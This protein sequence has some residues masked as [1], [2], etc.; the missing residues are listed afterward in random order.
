MYMLR[1][2]AELSVGW[3]RGIEMAWYMGGRCGTA[4]YIQP[5]HICRNF[6]LRGLSGRGVGVGEPCK[7]ERKKEK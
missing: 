6:A 5:R 3:E 2:R 1:E 7:V 4:I